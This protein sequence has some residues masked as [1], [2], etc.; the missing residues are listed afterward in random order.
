MKL[1]VVPVPVFD[2][3]MA[4]DSYHLMFESG[5]SL[6]IASQGSTRADGAVSPKLLS[7]LNQIGIEAFTMGK[8]LFIPFSNLT[9]IGNFEHTLE[10]PPESVI[11]N[12]DYSITPESIYLDRI[13][14]AKSQGYRFCFRLPQEFKGYEPVLK[15][16]DF[17]M[18]D[19][20]LVNKKAAINVILEYPDAI[21]IASSVN[22]YN[23]LNLS[24]ASG[25]KKF[26]GRFY[27]IPI[28]VGKKVDVNPLKILCIQLLNIVR[29]DNFDLDEVARVI[30]KDI[31]LSV[32]LLRAINS[33][34]FAQKIKTIQHAAA[35]LGQKEIK[36]WV[37]TSAASMLAADKPSEINKLSLTRAKFAEN[38]APY[39]EQA[40]NADSLFLM[41]LFSVLDVVLDTG[42]DEALSMVS[43]AD[44]IKDA[45]VR[46]TGQ[47]YPVYE[48][49]LYYEAADWSSVS[50][51]LILNNIKV[52]DIHEAYIQT[53]LWYRDLINSINANETEEGE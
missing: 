5:E 37:S 42:I 24:K 53:L 20:N 27:R 11:I 49:I 30:E 47:F 32:S 9:L 28:T 7:L 25:Y 22:T 51:F 43:V 26:E 36:K 41:G 31:A 6:I 1:F 16:M 29:D 45:L 10:L 2:K 48:F 19:Q 3:D 23:M 15:L 33:Q 34:K 4:V 46:H 35:M 38:L 40:I 21:P 12:L 17:I 44:T 14:G 39:F 8:P 50:R 18:V 52:E 13:K